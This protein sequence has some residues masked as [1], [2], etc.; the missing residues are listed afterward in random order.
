MD[1]NVSEDAQYLTPSA[2]VLRIKPTAFD[3]G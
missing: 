1:L 2:D 3:V